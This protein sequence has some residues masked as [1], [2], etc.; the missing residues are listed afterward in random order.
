MVTTAIRAD[1]TSA[2][3]PHSGCGRFTPHRSIDKVR[4]FHGYSLERFFDRP[5]DIAQMPGFIIR[6]NLHRALYLSYCNLESVIRISLWG[7]LANRFEALLRSILRVLV[8]AFGFLGTFPYP[9]R[10]PRT[11]QG[12]TSLDRSRYNVI[13]LTGPWPSVPE[14]KNGYADFSSRKTVVCV[15]PFF[16]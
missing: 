13:Y 8:F 9:F 16:I 3:F 6:L 7:N 14:L 2:S 4:Q 11:N 15:T 1:I 12:L 10:N 5:C